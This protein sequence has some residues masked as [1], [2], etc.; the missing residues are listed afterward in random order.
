MISG[1]SLV[2][3][4]AFHNMFLIHPWINPLYTSKYTRDLFFTFF[5]ISGAFE[6]TFSWYSTLLINTQIKM[7]QF[8][9]Q[10]P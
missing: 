4:N 9:L 1:L 2:N 7:L 5:H 3:P 8:T 10:C 6:W